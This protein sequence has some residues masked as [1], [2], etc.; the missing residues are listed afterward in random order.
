MAASSSSSQLRELQAVDV[1]LLLVL[2][3]GQLLVTA[4][5][6]VAVLAASVVVGVVGLS[7]VS[8]GDGVLTTVGAA[9]AVLAVAV[10][11]V[12]V[13]FALDEAGVTDSVLLLVAVDADVAFAVGVDVAVDVAV[14]VLC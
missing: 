2:V 14:R 9:V 3:D 10:V 5:V 12:A 8:A 6:A 1:L 4:E 11:V 7:L 13:A